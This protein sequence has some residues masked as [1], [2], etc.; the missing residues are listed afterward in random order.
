MNNFLNNKRS[1]K[2]NKELIKVIQSRSGRNET[3]YFEIGPHLDHK[4]LPDNKY[5]FTGLLI[6]LIM[7]T[8]ANIYINKNKF[9]KLKLLFGNPINI[10]QIVII[11][12]F[13]TYS[14]Y[15]FEP[16]SFMVIGTKMGFYAIIISLCAFLEIPFIPFW[17]THFFIYFSQN[18]III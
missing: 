14:F 2:D 9:K 10:W 6:L 7:V 15:Y 18:F 3:S 1:S 17:V 11:S 8:I 4:W 16:N 13:I 12:L 5:I